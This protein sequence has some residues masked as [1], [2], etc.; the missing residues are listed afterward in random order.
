MTFSTFIFEKATVQLLYHP[1]PQ[2]LLNAQRFFDL[3]ATFVPFSTVNNY[4]TAQNK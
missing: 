1:K 4:P 3:G 2:P